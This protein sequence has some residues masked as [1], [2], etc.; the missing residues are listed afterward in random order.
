MVPPSGTIMSE[1]NEEWDCYGIMLRD[2]DEEFGEEEYIFSHQSATTT[3][4][5]NAIDSSSECEMQEKEVTEEEAELDCITDQEMR[6]FL[7]QCRNR[8]DE[9]I[10]V[11]DFNEAVGEDVNGI[12]RIIQDLNM[13]DLMSARH[14][15][16]LPATYSRGR[17]CLDY[18]FAMAQACTALQK[19][20]YESFGHRYHSDH[21]AYF[22][23]FDIRKLFGTAIQA[24]SKFEPR[25]LHSTNAKQVTAFLRRMDEI[26]RSCNA[27]ARGDKL[28]LPVRRDAHA[29]RLDFDVLNGSLVSERGI[30]AFQTPEWSKALATARIRVAVLQKVMTG[31]KHSKVHSQDLL[32]QYQRV[33][34]DLVFPQNKAMCQQYLTEARQSVATL[35]NESFAQRDPRIQ[36]AY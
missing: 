27:Y 3:D 22:F 4:K 24:L 34:E 32:D 18:G 36:A 16:D 21:R 8:G 30:P 1:D 20:G 10:L 2:D 31:L 12:V 9:L 19:C 23:D 7:Q 25:R 6:E 33:C 17:R 13:T 35:V 11:G 29:E 14:N 5:E 26:M 15:Q 28:D